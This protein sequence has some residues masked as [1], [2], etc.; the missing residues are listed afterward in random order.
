MPEG[1]GSRFYTGTARAY[2]AAQRETLHNARKGYLRV[3]Y[4]YHPYYG[5]TL[6]VF[7]ANG[8]LRDLVY[9]R[10]PN[11]TTR[12]IPAWMFDESICASVRCADRAIIDCQALL[13]LAQLLDLQLE[14][15]GIERHESSVPRPKIACKISSPSVNTGAGKVSSKRS[16]GKRRSK[17]VCG[18]ASRV[19]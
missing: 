19:T 11:N 14:N 10:M 9:V 6:E 15:R 1:T 8:G 2:G 7:G 5:Q 13:R 16:N 4:P 17:Q 3:L 18:L 12:G